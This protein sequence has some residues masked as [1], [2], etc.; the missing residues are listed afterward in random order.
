MRAALS[1]QQLEALS[2]QPS[3]FS[4]SEHDKNLLELKQTDMKH[5]DEKLEFA[6][7]VMR[8]L[9]TIDGAAWVAVCIATVACLADVFFAGNW[10]PLREALRPNKA[11]TLLLFSPVLVF[12]TLVT[13]RQLPFRLSLIMAWMRAVICIFIF[14]LLNF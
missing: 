3:I 11:V 14:L 6:T 8:S 1:A 13:L 9:K 7:Y 5:I 12:L 4:R 2:A 10:L